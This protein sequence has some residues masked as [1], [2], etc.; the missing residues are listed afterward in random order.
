MKVGAVVICRY[1]SSR[2]P[3]KILREI[4]GKPLLQYIIERLALVKGLDDLVIATS[5]ESTDDPIAEYCAQHG[6]KCFRGSLN[7]VAERFLHCAE[8]YHFD[9]AIRI[10]GDNLFADARV[11]TEMIEVARKGDYDLVTNVKNRT[12]PKGMSV[13]IVKTSFYRAVF[14]TL[15]TAYYQEHVTIYFYENED[16]GHFYYHYNTSLPEASGVQLAIDTEEDYRLAEQILKGFEKDHTA[17]GF[18]DVYRAMAAVN[19][20]K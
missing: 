14:S 1:N 17:Y 15:N 8:A 13:E 20:A 16:S 9:Y 18:E 7:N 2:L 6:L 11:I 3:G 4:N 19:A 5:E 10:N 12:F